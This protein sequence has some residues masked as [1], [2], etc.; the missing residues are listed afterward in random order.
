MLKQQEGE[1]RKRTHTQLPGFELALLR[2]LLALRAGNLTNAS[3]KE[4]K[5]KIRFHL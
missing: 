1:K 4:T 2:Q 5:Y 3:T